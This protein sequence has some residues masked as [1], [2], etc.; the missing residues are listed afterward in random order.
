M[1]ARKETLGPDEVRFLRWPRV[2]LINLLEPEYVTDLGTLP[3]RRPQHAPASF[4]VRPGAE[5]SELSKRTL[6]TKVGPTL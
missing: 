6:P 4:T 5:F 3:V 1:N 2:S